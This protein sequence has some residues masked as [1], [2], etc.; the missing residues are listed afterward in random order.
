V[1]E[2]PEKAV[3]EKVAS[4]DR[5]VQGMLAGAGDTASLSPAQALGAAMERMD[6]DIEDPAAVDAFVHRWNEDQMPGA[7]SATTSLRRDELP[8]RARPGGRVD[9]RADAKLVRVPRQRS[10]R[11]R[12]CGASRQRRPH[13]RRGHGRCPPQCLSAG[14]ESR[15]LWI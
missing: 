2:G 1:R 12:I 15:R 8:K 5:W 7:W 9:R 3:E 14:D 6:V 4:I 13:S 10:G 11:D